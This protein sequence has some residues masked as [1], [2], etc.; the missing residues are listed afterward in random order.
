MN[1]LISNRIELVTRLIQDS[2]KTLKNKMGDDLVSVVLY[3]SYAREQS[4]PESDVDL[5][6]VA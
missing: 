2:I 4:S 5:L 1:D 3:G 6:I